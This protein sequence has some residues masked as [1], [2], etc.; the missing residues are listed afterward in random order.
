[1]AGKPITIRGLDCILYINGRISSYV[2][3]IS[4]AASTGAKEVYGIDQ[5]TPFEILMTQASIGGTLECLRTHDS[6]G[7][8]GLG[9]V[10]V[11]AELSLARYFF[12]QL[13]DRQTDTVILQ[14]PKAA[15]ASQQWAGKARGVLQGTIAF[16]GLAWENEY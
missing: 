5:M 10:P 6:A 11:E 14:I 7:A 3:G 8:E 16:K 1:M 13:V 2:T 9:I 12:L 4:W 15:C